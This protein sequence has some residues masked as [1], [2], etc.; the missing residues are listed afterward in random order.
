MAETVSILI[1]V[2]NCRRWVAQAIETA[3]NQTWR[4]CDVIVLDDGSVDG[5]LDVINQFRNHIRI[6]S[7]THSGQNRFRNLLTAGSSG[8]WLYFLD[9]DDELARNSVEEKM[10][11][12]SHVDAIYGST[13][14]VT[15]DTEGRSRSM[16]RVPAVDVDPWAAAFL[17]RLPN[18]SGFMF[19]R[20]ALL[21]AGGWDESIE[22]CTDYSLYFRLLLNGAT[23]KPAP[24]SWSLYRHWSTDQAVHRNPLSRVNMRL[25]LMKQALDALTLGGGLTMQR[26]LAFEQSTLHCIRALYGR[27]RPRARVE[28]RELMQRNQFVSPSRSEFRR[29]FVLAFRIGGYEFAETLASWHRVAAR[30]LSWSW[31]EQAVDYDTIGG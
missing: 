7:R 16:M 23:F 6:E 24:D 18:T 28:Y 22:V 8:D 19:R 14:A 31:R 2:Y 12:S 1:P 15:Y 17:W 5:S 30:S 27:D 4:A 21:A 3:L 10:R 20:S 9:A 25:Q 13:E 11:V 26:Q 29:L